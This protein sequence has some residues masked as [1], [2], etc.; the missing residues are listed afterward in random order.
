MDKRTFL[1]VL[2]L[3]L[4][5]FA[6]NLYFEN[7]NEGTV[8][9]WNEQLRGKKLHLIKTLE[10][11]IAENTLSQKDIPQV[12]IFS[13]EEG[14]QP[15]TTGVIYNNSIVTL[16]SNIPFP[17]IVYSK[18]R[19][20]QDKLQQY[21]RV[22]APEKAGNPVIFQNKEENPLPIAAIPEIGRY[23]LVLIEFD[24]ENPQAPMKTTLGHYNDGRIEIP[25]QQIEKLKK[26]LGLNIATPQQPQEKLNFLALFKTLDGYLPAGVQI[27]H[28]QSF[29]SL[30]HYTELAAFV[31]IAK[32]KSAN[33]NKP[34]KKQEEFYVIETPYQQLVFSNFG[35]ALKEINLPFQ[36]E[37]NTKSVVKEIEFDRDMV[38]QHPYNALFPAH[39]YYQADATGKKIEHGKGKLGGYYPLLR[40]DLIETGSHKSIYTKPKNYALNII[41]EYPEVADLIY[42]VKQFD[43]KSIVFESAQSHR[44][45]TKTFKISTEENSAPY[46]ID[47]SVKIEGDS[48]GLWLTS[49][50][51]EV[52]WI[53]GAAAP[54]IKYRMTRQT[55]SS[56]E[57]I[58]PPTD[59]LTVTS[60]YIDWIVNSNG[61]LGIIL[62]PLS[63]KEP[64]YRVQYVSGSAVPSRL[65]EIDEEYNLFKA[66]DMP[67]YMT[68][69]PL[70]TGSGTMDFRIFAGPFADKILDQ[71]DTFYT[72]KETGYNPDY[73][74]SQSFHGWFAFI[75][76]PFAKFL[77]ILMKFFY[78]MTHSWAFSIVLL[79]VALRVMLYPLNA[80]ST[81]SMLKMQ[82]IA[83][84]V[85]AIQ[86]RHKKDPKKAQVEIMNLYREGGVNPMSGCF[87]LLIQ[88]PFLIGMFDLLKSTF[89]LRGASFIPGWIDDLSAPDVLFS[90]PMPIFFIGNQFHLLPFVLGGVMFLQQR[91]MSTLP[92]DPALLTE[93]QRQQKAMGSIMT[94]VFTIMFYN[95]PSGLNIYWLSS[96]ILGI[97]QQWWTTKTMKQPNLNVIEVKPIK[98]DK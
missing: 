71:V 67:G 28:E 15:I 37:K 47:L 55:K 21:K 82:Q 84:Q 53:S 80:W 81:K 91:L 42:E 45:I 58:T 36:T 12:D 30:D 24:P 9:E 34:T 51:P 31:N 93:Q 11:E 7:Q 43:D 4:A 38:A 61:F 86:E 83:P 54:A 40:R 39:A 16:A 69:L 66:Q 27:D 72:N 17:E 78:S 13:D 98:K 70:K 41:S 87:P 76:E 1:F 48:R 35:G 26:D 14:L 94:V 5:L 50:V 74:A 88:M 33:G 95:F 32:P 63:D 68:L 18:K 2:S 79:T 97:L 85:T 3:T 59:N 62:D 92:S 8:T 65:V 56:V 29:C 57:V 23:N 89:E 20:S 10:N 46:C 96:M 64:G 49:G 19:D 90:W 22:N 6:V 77:L 75:S 52:E 60:T 44:R 73:K 25:V